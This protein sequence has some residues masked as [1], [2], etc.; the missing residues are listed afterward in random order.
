MQS[1]NFDEVLE[2]IT[3]QD[4]RYHRE[5][6]LFMREALEH[7]QKGVVSGRKSEPR[8][9]S[10]QELLRGLRDY[11]LAQ[12]GPMTRTVLEEWGVRACEDFGEIVFNMVDHGL[13]SK[14][15][16]D[17]REDFKGGFDFEEAFSRPFRPRG[18]EGTARPSETKAGQP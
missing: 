11:A 14:T 18:P 1:L 13:L 8:H 3:R 16:N 12:Y 7:A 6:Y 9:V 17:S 5:V 10:G 2:R 15:E 4:P